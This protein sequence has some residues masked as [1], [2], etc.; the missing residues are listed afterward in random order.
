[1]LGDTRYNV[2]KWPQLVPPITRH[3]AEQAAERLFKRFGKAKEYPRQ[4]TDLTFANSWCNGKA[5]SCWITTKPNAGLSKGWQR[6]A[7]DVS[8][9]VFR[10]RYPHL[11]P[12]DGGHAAL[13]A[14]VAAH[15]V[16][17]G[18][19][20]GSLKPK[21]KAKPSAADKLARCNELW[22]QWERKRK[23]AENAQIKLRSKIR[24]LEKELMQ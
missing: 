7:H 22:Q 4:H 6:L 10:A 24:R 14:E 19:L 12:H 9:L 20:D 17:A 21:P 15:I 8:H 23:R 18:W 3:E 16:N 5:R 1:M 11:R 2:V 13:E